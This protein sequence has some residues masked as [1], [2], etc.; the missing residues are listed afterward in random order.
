MRAY[1]AVELSRFRRLL[2]ERSL[3]LRASIREALL[4]GD[5]ERY[6]QI[7]GQVHDVEEDALADLLIDLNLADIDHHIRELRDIEAA[8]RRLDSGSYGICKRCGELIGGARLEAYPTA[9]R[10]I[11]CQRLEE[12][13]RLGTAPASM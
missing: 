3:A 13:T 9:Q 4:R 7:A 11:D 10:C 12:H 8:L 5:D 1:P 2:Q 6:A